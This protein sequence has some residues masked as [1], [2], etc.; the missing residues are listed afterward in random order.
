MDEILLSVERYRLNMVQ[1]PDRDGRQGIGE[2]CSSAG[3]A[4]QTA[5]HRRRRSSADTFFVESPFLSLS[6]SLYRALSLEICPVC[7]NIRSHLAAEES[8]QEW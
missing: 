1:T 2:Y 3:A 6:L 7:A 4:V 5:V 8:G